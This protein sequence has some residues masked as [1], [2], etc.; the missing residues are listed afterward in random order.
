MSQSGAAKGDDAAEGTQVD[1]T[2]L[3][4]E[5]AGLFFLSGVWAASESP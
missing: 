1:S 2:K 5:M 3:D 4:E